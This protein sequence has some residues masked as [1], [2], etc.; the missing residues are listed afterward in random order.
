M[1]STLDYPLTHQ[2]VRDLDSPRRPPS[3][4]NVG[5][6][7]RAASTVLGGL[8]AGFGVAYCGV[9][10]TLLAAVGAGLAF[11]GVTGHCYGY[12]AA[13]VNTAR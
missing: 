7:E 13:G 6:S 11:R 5:P 4:V 1:A 2:G 10:G 12:E 9:A 3:R 8:L